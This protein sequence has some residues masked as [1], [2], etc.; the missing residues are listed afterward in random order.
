MYYLYVMFA[1]ENVIRMSEQ[2]CSTILR[3]IGRPFK[4][5][6]MNGLAT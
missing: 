2:P 1:G 5:D 3:T 4:E 6:R